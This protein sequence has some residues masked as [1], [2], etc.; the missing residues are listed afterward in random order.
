MSTPL[1]PADS[2]ALAST[3]ARDWAVQVNTST[4]ET[5]TWVFVYGLSQ[6]GP[7]SDITLQDDGDIHA[8]GYKSQLATAIGA[9]L[10]LQGLRKGTLAGDTF[11][12]DPGQEALRAKGKLTGYDNIA[13]VRYWR[14]DDLTDAFEIR[15]AVSWVDTAAD[16][17]ALQAFTCT[18]TGRGKPVVITKPVTP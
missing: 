17:E 10:E 1:L 6:V 14:T 5:P 18:L 15:A 3:L 13:H 2:S 9:N 8:G 12:P 16:K 4:T 7:T 11:T